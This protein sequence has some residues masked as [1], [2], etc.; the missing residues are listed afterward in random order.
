[1]LFLWRGGG[2]MKIKIFKLNEYDYYAGETLEDCIIHYMKET[3]L[4]REEAVD[5]P[6]KLHDNVLDFLKFKDEDSGEVKTFR[7]EL[8][9]KIRDEVEFPCLFAS[10]EF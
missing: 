6:Y 2:Q 1:M 5:E 3:G 9:Q 4:S 8:E 10:A 7:E